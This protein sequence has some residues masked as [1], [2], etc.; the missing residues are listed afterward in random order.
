MTTATTTATANLELR[1]V[2]NQSTYRLDL[3]GKT[4]AEFRQRVHDLEQQFRAGKFTPME[5][6]PRPPEVD[7]QLEILNRGDGEA[8]IWLGGDDCTLTLELTGPGPLPASNGGPYTAD[9]QYSAP[10]RLPPGGKHVLPLTRLFHGMRGYGSQWYWTEPGD[11][12]LLAHLQLGS[13]AP[14]PVELYANPPRG[15]K[16]SS[17]PVRVRVEA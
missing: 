1:L 11:Y 17:A 7:L 14:S 3:G 16:L 6:F 9:C 13:N 15:P 10:V 4:P 2:P 5:S 12:T 8:E